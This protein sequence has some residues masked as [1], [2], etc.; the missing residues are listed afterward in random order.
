MKRIITALLMAVALGGSM[1][2]VPSVA[3]AQL[4]VG[5]NVGYAPPPLPA[6]PQPFAPGPGFIWAPGYWSYGPYGYYWVPGTWVL[7][8]AVGL[9]WTP[10]YWAWNGGYYWW[11]AGYWGPTVGYYGGINYGYGYNGYGYWGG[12]WRGHAF[13]YNRAVSNVNVTVIHNT[14]NRTIVNRSETRVSYNGGHGGINVRPTSAQESYARERHISATTTQMRQEN[15]AK[16]NPAQRFSENH[17]RPEIAATTR[18]GKFTGANVVRMNRTKGSYEYHPTAHNTKKQRPASRKPQYA[19]KPPTMRPEN[20]NTERR[21]EAAPRPQERAPQPQERMQR[22][23][24]RAPQ[25]QE[26]TPR[27]EEH[28]K[29]RNDHKPKDNGRPPPL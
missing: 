11:H 1:L 15:L 21:Q 17:G 25:P 16:S 4:S 13:Y 3:S 22:P 26:R 9:L 8:P 7:A 2:A 23:E 6:Y 10:G 24:E 27:P 14:Y 12:Y 19:G 20:S 5:I 29:S 18:P 28:K